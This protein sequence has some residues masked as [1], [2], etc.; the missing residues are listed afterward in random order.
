MGDA[1]DEARITAIATATAE[2]LEQAAFGAESWELALKLLNAE[3]P[4][5]YLALVN[6]DFLNNRMNQAISWNLDPTLMTSYSEYYAFINP[7]QALWTSVKSG[8]ILSSE[9]IFPVSNIRN[10]EF[11]NDW[12]FKAEGRTAG[13]GLK[14]DASP[15]DTIYLPMHSP[16]NYIE[17]YAR[18]FTEILKRLRGPL[19]RAVRVSRVLQDA[20]NGIA[21]KAALAG[22]GSEAAFVID[23]TMRLQDA[24]PLATTLLRKAGFVS[25]RGGR[26]VFHDKALAERLGHLVRSLTA[27]A[28]CQVS[29]VGW[30]DGSGKWLISLT[31]VPTDPVQRLI[32]PRTQILIKLTN[33]ARPPAGG[34]LTEFGRLFHL[35]PAELRLAAAL[36]DGQSLSDAASSLGIT[37]ETARQRLKQVFQKTSTAKQSELCVMLARFHN[38]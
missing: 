13:I 36:G 30:D 28:L 18:P 23:H 6:Q 33:L 9:D 22:N 5:A 27:S 12:L 35:T 2:A 14:I 7:Y 4:N 37:F 29:R 11:Y 3:F 17:H 38:G 32:A 1:F 34:D 10:S 19:E 25:F 8:G 21:A 16:E 31:R 20:G 26:L 24:N 15:T